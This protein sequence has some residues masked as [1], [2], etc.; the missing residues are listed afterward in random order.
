MNNNSYK[1][2]FFIEGGDNVGKTTTIEEFKNPR[3]ITSLE[4]NRL[5]FSKYPTSK[6]TDYLNE[7]NKKLKQY[8][9]N[10]DTV[11]YQELNNEMINALLEDMHY[12]FTNTIEP[13]ALGDIVNIADRGFLSTYI[14]QYKT[15]MEKECG[16]ITDIETERNLL[17]MFILA[18]L[19]TIYKHTE[20][21]Y[22]IISV[23][24]LNNNNPDRRLTI[25]TSET[26]E[27]K[28]ALDN[29]TAL[30]KRVNR[31]ISNIIQ[32]QNTVPSFN[33]NIETISNIRF[34]YIDIYKRI[35]GEYIRKTSE[36]I[37][38]ELLSIINNRILLH[39]ERLTR[40]E[41][42]SQEEF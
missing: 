26:I 11:S 42:L 2:T 41:T 21:D 33:A 28:K 9:E 32:L 3:F 29:D 7:S 39:K 6:M 23:V 35:E 5:S 24:I 27:Y 22:P 16:E 17:S 38:E 25:D 1:Y 31:T 13:N 18:Y 8:L 19:N 12:S 37:C 10:N 14:Y 40:E 20:K 4:C 36:D 15:M 30:Q 34:Y